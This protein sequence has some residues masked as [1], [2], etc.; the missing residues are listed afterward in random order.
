MAVPGCSALVLG[1][2]Y[3]VDLCY[4]GAAGG[5]QPGYLVFAPGLLRCACGAAALAVHCSRRAIN[6]LPTF[7]LL[8]QINH[9]LN[10]QSQT[11]VLP[12]P[13]GAVP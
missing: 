12:A 4:R 2:R 8:K 1:A 6:G 11:M 3:I 13:T 5:F 7:S 9:V 10:E